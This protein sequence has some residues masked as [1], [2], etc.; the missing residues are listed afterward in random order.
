M[1]LAFQNNYSHGVWVAIGYYQPN[2]SDGSN[3]AKEGWWRLEP[4]QSA[5]VLWT[6]NEYSLFYAEA[7]DGAVWSSPSYGTN[8]PLQAF[9]WCWDTASSDGLEVGMRLITVSDAGWPWVGT[10]NLT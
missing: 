4:G 5:T 2:C 7:D 8:L 10:V 6:T 1:W 3:W 9:D